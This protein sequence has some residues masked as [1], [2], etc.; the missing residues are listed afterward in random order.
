MNADKQLG[1]GFKVPRKTEHL[2]D[3]PDFDGHHIDQK[4]DAPRLTRQLKK[5]V[6]IVTDGAWYTVDEIH[7]RTEFPHASISAQLRNLRKAKF[8][9]WAVEGR[10]RKNLRI[11]EY[12][13]IE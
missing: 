4:K 9:G 2:D 8:G 5:I 12:R 1:F 13:F 3:I 7:A 10:Y 11:F 6:E